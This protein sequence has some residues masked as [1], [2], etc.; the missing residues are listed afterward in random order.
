MAH[1]VAMTACDPLRRT[2]ALSFRKLKGDGMVRVY[3]RQEMTAST[4]SLSPSAHKP[5]EV[6]T[7]W[8]SKFGNIEVVKPEPVTV[9]QLRLAHDTEYVEGILSCK[10]KNGFSNRDEAVAKSLPFTSGAM[11]DAAREALKNG[12]VAAA[13]CSGFH[14]ASWDKA[15]GYCTFNGLMVTALALK[16]ENAVSRVG[17]IDFDMHEGDGTDDILDRLGIDWITHFSA[18]YRYCMPV[19]AGEFLEAI[20]DITCMMAGCDL[21]LYQ[22]GADPHINDPLGGFLTT[23]QLKNRD[24]RV[25]EMLSMLKIPVAWNLAGGYQTPLRKVLDIHDNT[26]EECLAVHG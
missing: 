12:K 2:M 19:Q 17:I 10:L 11:L 5:G 16:Q 23:R 13:P 7:S 20:P 15:F 8:L 25:F 6:V 1:H 14:H 18:G 9:E 21:V 22:A 24:R 3:Y 26:M 4:K